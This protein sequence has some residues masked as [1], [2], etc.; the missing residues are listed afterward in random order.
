MSICFVF[1]F[2]L[3]PSAYWLLRQ[4]LV[5]SP[6]LENYPIRKE[7]K[8]ITYPVTGCR[9]AR[10]PILGLTTNP[11]TLFLGAFTIGGAVMEV[12]SHILLTTPEVG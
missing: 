7:T 3:N 8:V 1:F 9:E 6:N 12:H 10:R 4:Q 5:L 11:Q 2:K